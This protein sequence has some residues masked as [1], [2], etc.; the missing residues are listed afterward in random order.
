[1]K[2]MSIKNVMI[3]K[4]HRP[5]EGGVSFLKHNGVYGVVLLNVII[6][7]SNYI[8]LLLSVSDIVHIIHVL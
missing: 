4:C 5:D 6:N 3:I 8:V 2:Q 1:M 7:D